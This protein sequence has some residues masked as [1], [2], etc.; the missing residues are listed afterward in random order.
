ML[1]GGGWRA[2]SG[3][4]MA[5]DLIF[6]FCFMTCEQEENFSELKI[7]HVSRYE[8]AYFDLFLGPCVQG[9]ALSM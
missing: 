8:N 2:S 7:S 1:V 5:F 3:L 4:Y 9:N 6:P